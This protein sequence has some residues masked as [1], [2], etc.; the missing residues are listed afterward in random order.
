[1]G[2][3]LK[4]ELRKRG[5]FAAV[6]DLQPRGRSKFQR[7]MELEPYARTR[8]I[9]IVKDA[10][11]KEEFYAEIVRFPKAKHDDICDSFAYVLDLITDY[12]KSVEDD[13]PDEIAHNLRELNPIS[14]SYWHDFHKAEKKD[15]KNWIEDFI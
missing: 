8:R 7:V 13:N 6:I 2:F 3:Y 14:Q 1:M 5:M 4:E 11:M 12:G 10:M 15:N 9:F